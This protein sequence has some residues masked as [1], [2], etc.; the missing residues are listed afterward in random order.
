MK[1]KTK[2]EL[3]ARAEEL[4]YNEEEWEER[5]LGA[6]EKHAKVMRKTTIRLPDEMIMELKIIAAD[7]G[8]PYQTYLRWVLHEHIK[9]KSEKSG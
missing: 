9:E 4:L 3:E 7:N 8:M 6:S 5:K 1:K 2:K